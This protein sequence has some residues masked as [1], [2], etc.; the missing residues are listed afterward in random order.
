[1]KIS[2]FGNNNPPDMNPYQRRTHIIPEAGFVDDCHEFA[3]SVG[4]FAAAG[5]AVEAAYAELKP[6]GVP[7][8][9]SGF[10][11]SGCRGGGEKA[12]GNG[13]QPPKKRKSKTSPPSRKAVNVIQTAQTSEPPKKR[14]NQTSP[15][16][17]K[18][19]NVLQTAQT[20]KTKKK[21]PA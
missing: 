11:T 4:K 16:S 14:K 15:Q 12:G 6:A 21:R 7:E 9:L 18:A 17:R 1:M 20:S 10:T 8:K 19:V 5:G 2:K 3:L 13:L